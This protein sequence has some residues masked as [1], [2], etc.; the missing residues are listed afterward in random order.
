MSRPGGGTPRTT[1]RTAVIA[2]QVSVAALLCL[3]SIALIA[4]GARSLPANAPLDDSADAQAAVDRA[5][6]VGFAVVGVVC[7]ILVLL[8]L[9]A[10]LRSGRWT[11]PFICDVGVVIPALLLVSPAGP[12]MGGLTTAYLF[13]LALVAAAGALALTRGRPWNTWSGT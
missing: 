2:T 7:A 6:D 3:G 1:G 10:W 11:L 9:R 8:S 12:T 5:L 13:V 4:G